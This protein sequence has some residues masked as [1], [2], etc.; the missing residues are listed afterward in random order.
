MMNLLQQVNDGLTRRT[1]MRACI[2][3]LSPSIPIP[4]IV[5]DHM[6]ALKKSHVLWITSFAC[7]LYLASLMSARRLHPW[8][9]S[10]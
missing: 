4:S 9:I 2:R 7:A 10:G 3:A 1:H 5:I 8:N 6:A